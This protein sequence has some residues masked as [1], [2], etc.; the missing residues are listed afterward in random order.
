LA[1]RGRN[2]GLLTRLRSALGDFFEMGG[3]HDRV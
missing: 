3:G 1:Q 2:G